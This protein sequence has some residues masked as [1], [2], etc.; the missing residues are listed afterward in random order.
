[1][2]G[3]TRFQAPEVDGTVIINDI[4]PGLGEPVVGSIG[5]ARITEVAGYDLVATLEACEIES[6]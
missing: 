6:D 3:R 5:T 1:L 2:T 4:G